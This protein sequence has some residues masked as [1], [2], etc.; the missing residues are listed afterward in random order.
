MEGEIPS[1][2]LFHVY[3]FLPSSEKRLNSILESILLR[4]N[5]KEKIASLYTIIKELAINGCRANLK[6]LLFL[7]N[8]YDITKEEDHKA[9]LPLLRERAKEKYIY[10]NAL[11]LK[12]KGFYTRIYLLHSSSSIQVQVINNASLAPFEKERIRRKFQ[13]AHKF[14]SL[15]EVYMD[16][17]LNQEEEEG[18]G[19][20]LIFC[21]MLL[22]EEGQDISTFRCVST[23]LKT[24]FE[25]TFSL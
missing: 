18:A 7:E 2:V 12:E 19:L 3:Q 16:S 23:P 21:L 22:K 17:S 4:Y 24:C 5:Q 1:K 20:G 14:S 15:A 6:R 25:F 9:I 11:K 13:K 8:G 10:E